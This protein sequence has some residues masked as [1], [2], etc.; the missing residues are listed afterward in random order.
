MEIIILLSVSPDLKAGEMYREG[1]VGR[2]GDR[3]MAG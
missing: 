3:R 2:H 1:P